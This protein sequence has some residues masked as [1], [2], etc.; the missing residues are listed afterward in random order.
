[1]DDTPCNR[2]TT[3]LFILSFIFSFFRHYVVICKLFKEKYITKE[4][5]QHICSDILKGASGRE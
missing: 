3:R 2:L 5:N 1:M 4:S